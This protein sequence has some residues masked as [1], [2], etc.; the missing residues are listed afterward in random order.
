MREKWDD[1]IIETVSRLLVP[2]VQLYAL[3]VLAHG[4][5]SPGGGFQG[6]CAF[7]ASLLLLA[8]VWSSE[9]LKG[10]MP[11][12]FLLGSSALGVGF[13]Y[14]GLGALCMAFGGNFLDYAALDPMLPKGKVMARYYGMALVETGVQFTVMSVMALIFLRL[15]EGENGCSKS[16]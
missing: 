7:A 3:Y 2:F 14:A 11:E 15:L 12:R 5:S 9:G 16:S 6:G 4:H 1:L 10:K 13:F 8:L